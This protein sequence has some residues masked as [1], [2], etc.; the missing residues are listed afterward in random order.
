MKQ[1]LSFVDKAYCINLDSRPERWQSVSEEF[2]R[3]GIGDMVERVS[4]ITAQDPRMGCLQSHQLCIREA[5]E[6]NFEN[7]VIF[8]DDVCFVNCP[9]DFFADVAA[10][11]QTESNW[12]LFYLGGNVMYP[13]RFVHQHVFRS[14]FFSTHAYIINRRA[15]TSC[16]QA[17]VP[18]DMWYAWNTVSYGLYPMY[19]TQ[20]ETFSDIRG[21]VIGNLEEAFGR[22]YD[23]LVKPNIVMRWVNYLR[24][25]YLKK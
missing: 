24:T 10:F 23:L 7:I 14:R 1:L 17:T 4:A 2:S 9:T 20:Q 6:Q 18:I 13:A 22:K 16:L 25:H 5:I 15:F 21:Q 12:D 11:L 19:A 3:A 8:E